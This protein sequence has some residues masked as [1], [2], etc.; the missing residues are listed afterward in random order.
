MTY[1]M[2]LQRVQNDLRLSDHVTPALR[3]LYGGC[4][5]QTVHYNEPIVHTGQRP[6]FSTHIV[7]CVAVNQMSLDVCST[8]SVH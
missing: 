8:D 2:S 7:R 6:E 3:L 4:G 5:L 1:L